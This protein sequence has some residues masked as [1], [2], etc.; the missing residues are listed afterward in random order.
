MTLKYWR[1]AF[2]LAILQ[3]ILLYIRIS[4]TWFTSDDFVN[5]EIVQLKSFGWDYLTYSAYFQIVPGFRL[6]YTIYWHLFGLNFNGFIGFALLLSAASTIAFVAVGYRLGLDETL[7]GCGGLLYVGL[8]QQLSSY[9]WM[10]AALH[11]MPALCAVLWAIY[12]LL[13]EK[14]RS[15]FWGAALY[16]VSLLFTPKAVFGV[17]FISVLLTHKY[18]MQGCDIK[19]AARKTMVT[20]LWF[21]PVLALYAPAFHKMTGAG[22]YL[23]AYLSTQLGFM[24]R[25]YSEGT[26]ATTFGLGLI[27]PHRYAT[28]SMVAAAVL[29]VALIA[30]LGVRADKRK[31]VLW[32]GLFVYVGL[33]M[34]SIC[35]Q[36]AWVEGELGGATSRYNVHNAVFL[37][38]VLM[39]TLAAV[40]SKVG[41]AM[42]VVVTMAVA[43]NVYVQRDNVYYGWMRPQIVKYFVH[44]YQI[45]GIPSGVVHKEVMWAWMRPYNEARLFNLLLK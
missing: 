9:L 18:L 2:G 26:I 41:K 43:L 45:S 42:I 36:R 3:G 12:V 22:S 4:E 23:G 31:R 16:G 27:G 10:T 13:G 40:T 15:R 37:L 6:F 8:P 44:N 25:A 29:G 33:A 34:F 30:A 11:E 17:L 1:L 24:A 5:F 35:L 19:K 32:A 20:M 38:I 28:R 14:P 21:V 39:L 7:V